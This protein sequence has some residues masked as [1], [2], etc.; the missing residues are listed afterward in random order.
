MGKSTRKRLEEAKAA[1]EAMRSRFAKHKRAPAPTQPSKYDLLY[2]IPESYHKQAIREVS[3]FAYKGKTKN[4]YKHMVALIR[5]LFGAY[6]VPK[7]LEDA[8]IEECE[9]N[10]DIFASWYMAV[11][12]G[13]SLYKTCTNGILTKKETHWFLQAPEELDIKQ[14][15][16]WARTMSLTG[17][18]GVAYRMARSRISQRAS[19][20]NDWWIQVLL[21]LLCRP[22]SFIL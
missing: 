3:D 22:I 17:D 5:H 18:I 19:I 1:E 13:K 10:G 20:K 21:E 11:A 12:L 6:S 7:Y 4:E 2:N 14:A 9:N 8:F 15:V 16:W